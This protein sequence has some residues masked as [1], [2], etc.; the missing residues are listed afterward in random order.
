MSYFI[1]CVFRF[2]RHTL[3]LICVSTDRAEP[4]VNDIFVLR[5]RHYMTFEL[6]FIQLALNLAHRIY[7]LPDVAYVY[8]CYIN[9]GHV[10]AACVVTRTY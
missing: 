2:H 5:P 8:L 4:V 1:P 7:L 10:V 3:L 6:Y 9:V